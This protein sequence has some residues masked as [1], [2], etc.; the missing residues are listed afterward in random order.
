ML[1]SRTFRRAL[2]PGAR[3]ASSFSVGDHPYALAAALG[4]AGKKRGFVVTDPGS[5]AVVASDP[6]LDPLAA[7]LRDGA[8]CPDYLRHEGL[9]FEVGARS[10]ALCG[11][12]LWNT[13]RGA[14]GGGIRMIPYD[15]IQTYVVDGLRLATGMGRKSALTGLWHGGGKG[16]IAQ[17]DGERHLTDAAFRR[18][19]FED[20]GDFVTGLRGC[21]VAAE[22][23]G[24]HVADMDVVFSRCRFTTCISPELGGSGNPSVPT[25]AGVAMGMEGA[26]HFQEQQAAAAAGAGAAA[27]SARP[28]EGKSIA[29]QGVGNVGRPLIGFLLEAGA[30]RVVG[31]DISEATV[32]LAQAE[33][34]AAIA[35]GRVALRVSAAGDDSILAEDVDIVS[36]CAWGGVINPTT[37]PTIRAGVVCG[38]AN[39]QLLDPADDCGLTA[40]GVLYVPDFAANPMGIV[41]CAN[42]AYGRVGALGT[43]E[44]PMIADRLGRDYEFSVYNSAL[45]VLRLAAAEG[46]STAE[47]A[48]SLADELC[49]RT[50]PIFGHRSQEIMDS[51]VAGDWAE[52]PL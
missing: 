7:F 5:G 18:S 26:V 47:A 19:I 27:P 38:A 37:A 3:C 31:A 48:N 29:V 44:D 32:A 36:P 10:G 46:I 49:T 45:K 12:F 4:G 13:A 17:P 6:C 22:D 43:T 1:A 25:A 8:A 30:S 40:R 41:N 21:Y 28:L 52:G 39:A 14:A 50:H 11:A 34:A 51:L 23:S 35:D 2:L 15:S 16:V 24:V 20:Y 42:E 33:H 9:F